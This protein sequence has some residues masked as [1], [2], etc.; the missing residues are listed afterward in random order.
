MK[1]HE[2]WV[3]KRQAEV[4]FRELSDTQSADCKCAQEGDKFTLCYGRKAF[5]RQFHVTVKLEAW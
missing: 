3:F 2:V 5:Y 1:S 4:I